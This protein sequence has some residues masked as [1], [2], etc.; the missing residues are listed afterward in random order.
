M[1]IKLNSK[2]IPDLK[3]LWDISRTDSQD[4]SKYPN[5]IPGFKQAIDDLWPECINLV[6]KLLR[7]IAIYLKLQNVEYFIDKHRGISNPYIKTNT[8]FRILYYYAL[9]EMNQAG[10]IPKNSYRCGEHT[11]G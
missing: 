5:E 4:A 6:Q 7:S 2:P 11:D 8:Q 1:Y 9:Y 3:E 10:K